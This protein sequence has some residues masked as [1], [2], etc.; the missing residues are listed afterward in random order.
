MLVDSF[1]KYKEQRRVW[2]GGLCG[3]K[4]TQ[5]LRECIKVAGQSMTAA[6][7]GKL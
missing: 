6:S 1:D 4:S 3:N 2:G 7:L 5:V